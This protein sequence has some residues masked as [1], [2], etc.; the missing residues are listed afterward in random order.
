MTLMKVMFYTFLH[1]LNEFVIASCDQ[2]KYSDVGN[3]TYCVLKSR[4]FVGVRDVPISDRSYSTTKVSE[5]LVSPH[6]WIYTELQNLPVI[7]LTR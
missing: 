7:K 3:T 5:R 2:I 6:V 4:S 1:K